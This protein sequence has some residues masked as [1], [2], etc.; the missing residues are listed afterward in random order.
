MDT[1]EILK[2]VRR[3]E[4]TTRNLVNEVFAGEY[5]SMFK[6][7]GLEFAEVREYQAGDN[8]KDIDWNVSARM[9]HPYIKKYEE[10][11]E[12][13]VVL[14]VDISASTVFGTQ[15]ALKSEYLAELAAVLAFS[16]LSNHDKV[17]LLLFSDQVEIFLSPRKGKKAVLQ[18][19]RE[20]LYCQ[21]QGKKTSIN[22]ALTHLSHI[23]KKR[24]IVFLLSDFWDEGYQKPL[25]VLVQ[26][27]DVIAL[28]ILDPAELE[29]PSAGVIQIEDPETGRTF[30]IDTDSKIVRAKYRQQIQQLQERF[31]QVMRDC[32]VD[33]VPLQTNQEYAP[34]LHRFFQKRLRMKR[35]KRK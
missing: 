15:R 21:P 4:I 9:G 10:S 29:L 34:T 17:S 28:Q 3:I 11:R 27:H 24:S 14:A 22:N 35:S 2:R 33:W 7:Q 5:H 30:S 6:G 16:A 18:M 13:N 19:I 8:Y 12:L 1:G 31:N 25:K 26:K 32:R 20:I 23:I